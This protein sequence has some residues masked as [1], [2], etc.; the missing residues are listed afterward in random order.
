MGKSITPTFRIEAS[1]GAVIPMIWDC[2]QDGRPN[3]AN[4]ETLVLDYI[5]STYPGHPNEHIS[6]SLGYIPVPNWARVVRQKTGEVVAQWTAPVFMALPPDPNAQQ[7]VM[8]ADVE[9]RQAA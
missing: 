6:R 4:L 2:K 9:D 7:R 3:A 5:V 1:A 8:P